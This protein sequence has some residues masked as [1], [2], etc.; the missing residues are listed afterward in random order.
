MTEVPGSQLHTEPDFA[1]D[2]GVRL[3]QAQVAYVTMGQLNAARSNAILVTHGYTS[4]H[5]FVQAGSTAAEGSWSELV[6]PGKAIDTERFFMVSSNALGSCYGSSGPASLDPSTGKAYG[7]TFPAIGFGD[8]V[9]LQKALLTSLGIDRLY[10]V[11]G[12]SMGG[13]QALQWGVQYPDSVGR[14]VVALS[15]LSGAFVKPG[16][17]DTLRAALAADPGW[18]GGWPAPGSMKPFL[19]SLRID[20]LKRYGL[21]AWLANQGLTQSQRSQQMQAMAGDWADSFDA[22]CLLT[23]RDAIA[24]FDVTASAAAI[25]AKVL[26]VLGTTDALFPA[27]GGTHIVQRLREQ[28]VDA[29][30]QQLDSNYGHLASGLDWQRWDGPLRDFLG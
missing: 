13:F 22:H 24:R 30:F 15:A 1:L 17:P 6:G 20:T 18:N 11:A 26:L 28:G 7:P 2:C 29:S 10:A 3:A 25:K 21:D 4:S 9:R 8:I 12:V 23:L 5:T 27:H 14:L 19:T 16:G